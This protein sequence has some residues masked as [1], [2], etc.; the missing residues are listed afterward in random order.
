MLL[1]GNLADVQGS[2]DL[3]IRV[4]AHEQV[5]DFALS[6]REDEGFPAAGPGGDGAVF[7]ELRI[8]LSRNAGSFS[9]RVSTRYVGVGVLPS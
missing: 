4:A 8:S 2:C 3:R 1:H 5:G 7:W 6:G 9:L